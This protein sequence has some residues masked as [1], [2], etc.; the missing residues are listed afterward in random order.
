M[1]E[2]ATLDTDNCLRIERLLPGPIERIWQYLTDSDKRA[3]WL[4]V[5]NMELRNGGKVDFLF[6][7]CQLTDNDDAPPAKYGP[8]DAEHSMLGQ[9]T[10]CE[11]PHLLSFLW[12]Q[13][14]A[15][16]SEVRFELA[17]QGE[18]VLLVVI[19]SR[20]EKRA[21]ILSVAGGWHTHLDILLARLEGLTPAGFWRTHTRLEQEYE[22]IFSG[23]AR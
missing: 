12:N 1:S 14:S 7:N 8:A 17:P 13:G 11:P 23:S 3:T 22:R 19:H 15:A 20:L 21:E 2:Y 9:I 5:G 6:R 18:K 4:A 16:E 10:A